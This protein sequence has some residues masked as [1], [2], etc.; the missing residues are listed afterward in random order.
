MPLR[1]TYCTCPYYNIFV[2]ITVHIIYYN[3]K[4]IDNSIIFDKSQLD[5]VR[6]R[7]FLMSITMSMFL[8]IQEIGEFV[9]EKEQL[10]SQLEMQQTVNGKM[11]FETI[12]QNEGILKCFA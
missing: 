6:D 7:S 5:Q 10:K 2:F 3:K 4:I 11:K 12:R 1:S 9:E 8:N